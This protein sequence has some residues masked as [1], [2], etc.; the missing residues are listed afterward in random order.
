MLKR[1]EVNYYLCSGCGSLETET[2]YWLDEA[3]NV[4]AIGDDLGAGQRTIDLMLRTSA[5]LDRIALPAG[6][7]CIDFGGGIGLFTR[8][9]RDR[10]F[11]FFC[12]DR[13]AKPF[14]S[15][16]YSL[17]TMAA[18]SPEV[19]TAFEVMEHFPD[20]AQD[21]QQ[22]FEMRPA[23]IVA[24]TELFTGQ[25][26]SW[27]YLAEG[28]GQHVFFYSP[29]A[30]A[31]IAGRFGYWLALVGGLIVFVGRAEI[32]RLGMT[33]DSLRNTLQTLARDNMLMR[34]GLAL[35]V[36]HQRAPYEFIQREVEA[37]RLL[38]VDPASQ[39]R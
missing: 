39:E 15:D 11:N 4:S 1:Y 20:P 28:T 7:E 29:K 5:L 9:M 24:T 17:T 30:L 32:G 19:V 3:Y 12:F 23:F 37:A 13:Y 21:L 34:H 10:G 33:A 22:L 16:R 14:F 27:P 25:D 18:R 8:L 26:A 6:A 38:S 31:G 35:F 2:P 36:R